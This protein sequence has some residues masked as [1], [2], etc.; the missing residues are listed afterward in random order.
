MLSQAEKDGKEWVRGGPTFLFINARI[1]S[2]EAFPS[3]L[4]PFRLSLRETGALQQL[5]QGAI[6]K[7]AVL[8]DIKDRPVKPE[9]VDQAD[10]R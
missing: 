9:N 6:M 7:R 1:G 8:A 3:W 10:D 4:P 2:A 5:D